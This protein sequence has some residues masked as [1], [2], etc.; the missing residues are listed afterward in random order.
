MSKKT[1]IGFV[2]MLQITSAFPFWKCRVE[3]AAVQDFCPNY[4]PSFSMK[5][6]K[7]PISLDSD[8]C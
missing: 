2:P 8:T 1:H 5:V 7:S 6:E 4:Q 3:V